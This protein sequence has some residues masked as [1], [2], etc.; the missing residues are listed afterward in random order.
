MIADEVIEKLPQWQQ[1]LL[2]S[3]EQLKTQEEQKTETDSRSLLH[4]CQQNDAVTAGPVP[5]R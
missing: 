2:G 3:L 5:A 1:W 4:Y